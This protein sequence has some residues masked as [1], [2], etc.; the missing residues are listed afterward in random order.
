MFRNPS[1]R[2][3]QPAVPLQRHRELARAHHVAEVR[4]QL[5]H[6]FRPPS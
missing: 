2:A 1:Q 3:P 5:P 6:L 4:R